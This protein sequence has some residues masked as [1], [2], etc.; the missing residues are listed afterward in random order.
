LP[1]YAGHAGIPVIAEE[2]VAAGRIEL[3]GEYWL[4][5]PLTVRAGRRRQ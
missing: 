1:V 2:E 5:D 4:V 3:P